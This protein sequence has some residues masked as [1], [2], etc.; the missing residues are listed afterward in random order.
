MPAHHI[1]VGRVVRA[2]EGVD[3]PAEC[4]DKKSTRCVISRICRLR[5]VF[6]EAVDAFYGVLDNYTL[7]DLVRNRQALVSVLRLAPTRARGR[8]SALR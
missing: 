2:S 8:S 1:V 5:G 4:F 7:D 6:K 3:M